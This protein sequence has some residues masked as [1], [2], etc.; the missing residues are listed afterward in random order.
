M[1]QGIAKCL[2]MG[3]NWVYKKV[4]S[5]CGKAHR[6]NTIQNTLLT[7]FSAETIFFQRLEKLPRPVECIA[8]PTRNGSHSTGSPTPRV[9]NPGDD[10]ITVCDSVAARASYRPIVFGTLCVD[11]HIASTPLPH[12]FLV[13]SFC[14]G[15]NPSLCQSGE[16]HPLYRIVVTRPNLSAFFYKSA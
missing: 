8:D 15:R 4:S 6:M 5:V 1:P 7:P 10:C 11:Y 3:A 2:L 13:F 14:C 12:S 16:S 9:R